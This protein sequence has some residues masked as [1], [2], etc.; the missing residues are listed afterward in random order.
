MAARLLLPA[1]R[2]FLSTRLQRRQ[3]C[4]ITTA[5]DDATGRALI[6][7]EHYAPKVILRKTSFCRIG[8]CGRARVCR[9]LRNGLAH[10]LQLHFSGSD[11]TV[12]RDERRRHVRRYPS[13]Y[14]G[15]VE[16]GRRST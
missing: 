1:G 13:A 7:K 14:F 10:L 12:E 3:Y 9:C 8:S 6:S 2:F 11:S 4:S 5:S 16:R 15:G